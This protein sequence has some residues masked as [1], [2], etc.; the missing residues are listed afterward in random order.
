MDV[1]S[2]FGATTTGLTHQKAWIIGDPISFVNNPNRTIVVSGNTATFNLN[3]AANAAFN[4]QIAYTIDRSDTTSIKKV[5]NDTVYVKIDCSNNVSGVKGPYSLGVPD[6]YKLV[7]V[8]ADTSGS[9]TYSTANPDYKSYFTLDNGQRDTH[10]GLARLTANGNQLA[11]RLNTSTTLLV[12]LEAFTRDTSQGVGFFNANS[13]PIDDV[14]TSNTSTI[15]SYEIPTYTGSDGI[16]YDLRN[17]IDFRP[18]VANTAAYSN[19]IVSA[20]I[21][22]GSSISFAANPYLPAPDSIFTTDLQYYLART[23]RIALDTTGS[24]IVTEGNPGVDN[25]PAPPEKTGTMSLALVKVPAYPSLTVN[26]AK[27]NGRYDIAIQAEP[28]QIKRY[29]MKDIGKF[30]SRIKTLE[31]YTSLS[32]LES[33][34]AAL[35]IRSTQTGQTRFQNGIFVDPFNGFDLCNTQH[36]KFYIAVDQKRSEIRPSFFQWRSDMIFDSEGSSNV[37]KHGELVMLS[38]TSDTPYITQSY[39]SKYRNCIEGNIYTWRGTIK[40]TP[41]GS[42]AP[43][44]VNNPDV[45]NN[46]DLAQNFINLQQAWGTQWGNWETISTTYA[47]TLITASSSSSQHVGSAPSTLNNTTVYNDT[48]TNYPSGGR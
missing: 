23:D 13:Y 38:H 15:R 18:T 24:I 12:E 32:L 37:Q 4:V 25:P 30:D 21:N 8:Y 34:A 9:K 44:T 39:A 48:T 41:G 11:G 29:T 42:M 27:A 5:L 17:V 1:D 28:Q 19:T 14:N 43:D 16:F 6:V 10:Y 35:Q 3:E 22:P 46:I 45:V 47:N 36:P 31:Y 40:L 33:S 2:P 7:G 20:T 26:E